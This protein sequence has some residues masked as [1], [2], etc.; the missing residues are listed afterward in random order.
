MVAGSGGRSA[1][2]GAGARG[3]AQPAGDPL[4]HA[5]QARCRVC[6]SVLIDGWR[7]GCAPRRLAPCRR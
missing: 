1:R 2:G 5:A 7:A 6:A 3:A 4:G